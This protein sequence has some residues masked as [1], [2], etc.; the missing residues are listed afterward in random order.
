MISV[1]YG[2]CN[3]SVFVVGVLYLGITLHVFTYQYV[4]VINTIYFIACDCFHIISKLEFVC[5]YR[6]IIALDTLLAECLD[7]V[8]LISP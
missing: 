3:F 8:L 6:Y 5:F 4:V 2:A 7:L 1:L